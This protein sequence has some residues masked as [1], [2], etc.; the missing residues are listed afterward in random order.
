R[1]VQGINCAEQIL[2]NG[3]TPGPLN[4]NGTNVCNLNKISSSTKFNGFRF[5]GL[6]NGSGTAKTN[7]SDTYTTSVIGGSRASSAA[8]II[9]VGLTNQGS[10]ANSTVARV[11]GT[12]ANYNKITITSPAFT[13]TGDAAGGTTIRGAVLLNATS[14]TPAM[15]AEN[16]FT[17][18]SLANTDTITITWQ[19]TLS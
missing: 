8:G 2:F 10:P 4:T 19:I 7:G 13:F 15:F 18:V 17:G 1:T 11:D 16:A 9:T 5:I 6:I 3:L 12:A 14:G